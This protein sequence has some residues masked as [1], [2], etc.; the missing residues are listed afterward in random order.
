M[1]RAEALI[2]LGQ[3]EDVLEQAKAALKYAKE[4][5][6]FNNGTK[7]AAEDILTALGMAYIYTGNRQKAEDVIG[8]LS[9]QR[10]HNEVSAHGDK[11]QNDYR[12]DHRK[13]GS[14]RP[15]L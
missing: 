6:D 9:G 12:T 13:S 7:N 4:H 3:Y 11:A 1:I 8:E 2:E 5:G 15:S 14:R 10:Q